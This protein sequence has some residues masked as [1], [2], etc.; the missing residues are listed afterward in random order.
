MLL[1]ALLLPAAPPVAFNR[2]VRPILADRCFACHGPDAAHR[3]AGL[4][5]D[6][7]EGA[8]KVDGVIVPGKPGQSEFVRRVS[9]KHPDRGV[10]PPRKTGKAVAPREVELL[11]R[12]IAEGAAYER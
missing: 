7:R 8:M 12:W 4:R 2:D 3:K 5:L 1:L 9:L 11:R 10:M 6:T